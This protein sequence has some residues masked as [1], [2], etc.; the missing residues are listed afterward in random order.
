M[1]NVYNID[2]Y[3]V[4]QAIQSLSKLAGKKW[5]LFQIH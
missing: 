2:Q 4:N 1:S 5:F 3:Y